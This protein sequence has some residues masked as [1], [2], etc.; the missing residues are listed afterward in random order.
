[1]TTT[2]WLTRSF[3]CGMCEHSFKADVPGDWGPNDVG[4][5]TCEGCEPTRVALAANAAA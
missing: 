4:P 2:S 5:R 1:V 3:R